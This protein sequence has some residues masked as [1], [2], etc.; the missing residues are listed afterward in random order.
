MLPRSLDSIAMHLNGVAVLFIAVTLLISWQFNAVAV[1]RGQQNYEA[2]L[3]CCMSKIRH[4]RI[5]KAESKK[6]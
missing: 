6:K 3:G 1:T 2:F 5:W 4:F